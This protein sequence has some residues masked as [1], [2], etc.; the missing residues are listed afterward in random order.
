MS[1]R[2]GLTQGLKV[3][4]ELWHAAN[5]WLHITKMMSKNRPGLV[6]YKV[7]SCEL[8]SQNEVLFLLVQ[9]FVYLNYYI[10]FQV[11]SGED[12]SDYTSATVHTESGADWLGWHCT[13]CWVQPLL[14]WWWNQQIWNHVERLL[15]NPSRCSHCQQSRHTFQYTGPREWHLGKQLCRALWNSLVPFSLLLSSA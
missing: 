14:H 15:R 1:T 13:I 12:A 3:V 4:D 5:K 9:M 6:L 10:E 8:G 7:E 2:V 11:G